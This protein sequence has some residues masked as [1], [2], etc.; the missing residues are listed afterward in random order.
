MRLMVIFFVRG[1]QVALDIACGLAYLHNRHII[2]LVSLETP[3]YYP[4]LI[5]KA[6][7]DLLT[8]RT[9]SRSS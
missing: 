3:K 4:Y 7:V 8:T 5:C 1:G 9:V 6:L 2:H